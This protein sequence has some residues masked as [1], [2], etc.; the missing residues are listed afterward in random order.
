MA[1]NT[2]ATPNYTL[3]RGKVYFARFTSGQVPGPFRYIGNT[4]EFNLTIELETLDHFSSDE[5]IREKD[6]SCRWK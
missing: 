6:D 3:G 1:L 4:P 2:N 5:G